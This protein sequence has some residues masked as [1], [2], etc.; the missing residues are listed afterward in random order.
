MWQN[1]IHR[2]ISHDSNRNFP[3]ISGTTVP[4]SLSHYEK[5]YISNAQKST[6]ATGNYH[7]FSKT[8]GNFWETLKLLETLKNKHKSP[9]INNQY[10][11]ATFRK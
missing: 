8:I 4:E 6:L 2:V 3:K 9:V 10:L 1:S 7:A 11:S 5:N